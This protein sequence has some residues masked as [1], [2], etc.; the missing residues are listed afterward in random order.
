MT[1]KRGRP[2][3]SSQWLSLLM[4]GVFTTWATWLTAWAIRP[5]LVESLPPPSDLFL[6]AANTDLSALLVGMWLAVAALLGRVV[7]LR[8]FPRAKAAKRDDAD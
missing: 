8:F 2:A 5:D 1:S 3:W 6:A 4:L 7:L